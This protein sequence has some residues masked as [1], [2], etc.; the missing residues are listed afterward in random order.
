M[1]IVPALAIVAILWILGQSAVSGSS[2]GSDTRAG[3]RL[4]AIVLAL[5]SVLYLV[6]DQIRRKS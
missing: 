3:L 2:T 6:G 4:A 1:K 5:A